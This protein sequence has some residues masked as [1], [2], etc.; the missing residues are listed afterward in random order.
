LTDRVG[1]A[2]GWG[3]NRNLNARLLLL[4]ALLLLRGM[5]VGF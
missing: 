3:V 1:R 4:D 5:A 2:I